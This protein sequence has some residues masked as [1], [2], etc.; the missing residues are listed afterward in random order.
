M[1]VEELVAKLGFEVGGLGALN[2]SISK[3]QKLKDELSS[4]S[5][6]SGAVKTVGGLIGAG[7]VLAGAFAGIGIHIANSVDD[8]SDFSDAVGISVESL[9]TLGFAGAKVGLSTEKLN[10][11]LTQFARYLKE[12]GDS[13]TIEQALPDIAD[14]FAQIK[15]PTDRAALALKMFGKGGVQFSN[16]LKDGSTGLAQMRA[17][18]EQLGLVLNGKTVKE[19][20]EF[21]DALVAFKKQL[22]GQVLNPIAKSVVPTLRKNLDLLSTWLKD[23]RVAVAEF[24]SVISKFLFG[25]I[26]GFTKIVSELAGGVINLIKLL[27]SS[28]LGS[29]LLGVAAGFAIMTVPLLAWIAAGAL[30]LLILEDINSY[31]EGG[32]SLLGENIKAWREFGNTLSE[33]ADNKASPVLRFLSR[34]ALIAGNLAAALG[35]LFSGD[36]ENAGVRLLKATENIAGTS[37][38]EI[39]NKVLSLE[40]RRGLNNFDPTNINQTFDFTINATPN[41][42]PEDIARAVRDSFQ[43]M[44]LVDPFEEAKSSLRPGR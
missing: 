17:E 36:L 3:I 34:L 26:S 44:P 40:K 41:Q 8:L 32:D 4:S 18:A 25:A 21:S 20:G 9:Q 33:F 30:V 42:S 14:K 23:N 19:F 29:A 27:G 7:G 39:D 6:L 24:L 28:G 5:G 35:N 15:N 11:S 38:Q 37:Q 22:V 43:A 31:L 2:Q 1:I 13:R 16:I 10:K 12:A